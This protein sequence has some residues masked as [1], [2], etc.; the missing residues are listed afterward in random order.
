MSAAL[1]PCKL[2]LD[3][4]LHRP[5]HCT[6]TF[7][8]CGRAKKPL[9]IPSNRLPL[10]SP[11]YHAQCMYGHEHPVHGARKT[12][13]RLPRS[14][15]TGPRSIVLYMYVCPFNQ[16]ARNNLPIEGSHTQ[17]LDL[18]LDPSPSSLSSSRPI[19]SNS[20][21]DLDLDT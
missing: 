8:M 15:L 16:L 4:M 7:R 14:P 5:M 13:P 17:S 6:C 12:Q 21:M 3:Y 18:Y 10:L 20:T 9:I 1:L 2:Y 19:P 11:L